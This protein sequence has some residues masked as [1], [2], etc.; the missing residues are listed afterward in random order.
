MQKNMANLFLLVLIFLLNSC[1][2]ERDISKEPIQF[3]V[4]G[5]HDVVIDSSDRNSMSITVDHISGFPEPVTIEF[6]GL[7]AGIQAFMSMSNGIPPFSSKVHFWYDSWRPTGVFPVSLLASSQHYQKEFGMKVISSVSDFDI[8]GAHDIVLNG[9][10]DTMP[11]AV[12]YVSG[13]REMIRFSAQLPGQFSPN[14]PQCRIIPE[15]GKPDFT[16]RVVFYRFTDTAS[17]H[18]PTKPG[19][20]RWYISASNSSTVKYDSLNVTIR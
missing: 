7:P 20:Y 3:K 12:T 8:S 1:S 10:T 6:I 19:T 2:K 14:A 13:M 4:S 17:N 9:L 15:T 16:A 5:V 11:I 18:R